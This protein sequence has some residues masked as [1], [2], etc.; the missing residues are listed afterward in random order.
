MDR[1]MAF[2]REGGMMMWPLLLCSL[3]SLTV[4]LERAIFW[5]GHARRRGSCRKRLLEA[6]Q[7]FGRGE[8]EGARRRLEGLAD[9]AAALLEAGFAGGR[10]TKAMERASIPIMRANRR[11]LKVLNT[12]IT[13]APMLGLLGTVAGIIRSFGFLG[14]AGAASP[15]AVRGVAGGIAEALITTAFG[16]A[17]AIITVIPYNYFSSRVEREA[18]ELSGMATAVEEALRDEDRIRY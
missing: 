14:R 5:T 9:P 12:V 4:S 15:L 6:T 3:L 13:V 17:I 11:G 10:G 8:L 16:L 2:F 1:L 7:L 18:E